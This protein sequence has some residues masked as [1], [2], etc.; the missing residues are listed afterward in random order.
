MERRKKRQANRKE[1]SRSTPLERKWVIE[2]EQKP[3]PRKRSPKVPAPRTEKPVRERSKSSDLSSKSSGGFFS[4]IIKLFRLAIFLGIFIIGLIIVGSIFLKDEVRSLLT[5]KITE[6]SSVILS[7]PYPITV[8]TNLIESRILNRLER[9]NYKKLDSTPTQ[10]GEFS[11]NSNEAY[12]DLRPTLIRPGETQA[13]GLFKL[14]L[15]TD[16]NIISIRHAL[17]QKEIS[18]IWLEPEIL[19]VLGNSSE[20]AVTRRNLDEFSPNLKNAILA[21]EDEHFY[22]HYGINPLAIIRAT[23]I[24]LRAGDAVQGG[25]TITQQLAKNLFFSSEKS[26][27]RKVKEAIAAILIEM[28]YSKD[29]IFEMYMNEIF[30]GQEGNFAIHGFAEAGKSFFGHDVS[31]LSLSESAMLA[32]MIKAPSAY[33][34]RK[35]LEKALNRRNLVLARMEEISMISK[36]EK[37]KAIEEKPDVIPATRTRRTAPYFVDYLQREIGGLLEN[38]S[39]TES[40]LKVVSGL[41]L[42]YQLCAEKAVTSGVTNLSSQ[43]SWIRKSKEPLQVSLVSVIPSSGEVRAW[44][45]G[46]DFGESQF[47]RV[48]LAKRQPGSTF[49]PFVYLTALDPKLNSYKTA[50]TTSI[51]IDEPVS[52][53]V[54]GGTWEPKNYEDEFQGEVRLRQALAMSLNIPTVRLAEKVGIAKIAKTGEIFG[55]G[56][57]L[58]KVPSLALGAGEVTAL[59]L[60]QAYSIIVNGGVKRVL[61]PFFYIL[62]NKNSSVVF[63]REVEESRVVDEGPVYLITDILR[64]VIENGTGNV[65][66]RIGVKG[67]IAGKTG[68]TNDARDSW[69]VGFTPRILTVV[70]VG[71]DSNKELKLTGAKAAA[72]IWAEYMKCIAPLEPELDFMP[73]PSIKFQTLDKT[74]GLLLTPNCP[75]ENSVT[76]VFVDGTEP[77]TDCNL[78]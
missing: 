40:S 52:I 58:P 12:I 31:E 6:S 11:L 65:V 68:T 3:E 19:S 13:A 43:Y 25:S 45:G 61:R 76:E 24:N 78:H 37:L 41:D 64:S 39:L 71:F 54:P 44:I 62:D 60:A 50:R 69:F 77:I 23:L 9:L 14:A 4:P 63:N 70:W 66:R 2:S 20:R 7:R 56:D 42:E 1:L 38:N 55:F 53:S 21:I 8:D 74:S 18:A 35:H 26:I 29:Q 49:K 32:G 73:P 59:N 16:G 10:A 67:P 34:P 5:K 51:L 15:G 22:Y 27:L 17:S 47:D 28:S 75:R 33:S 72:P 57:N 46:R 48:S 36:E 30:L